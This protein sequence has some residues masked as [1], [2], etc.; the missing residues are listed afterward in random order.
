MPARQRGASHAN[1]SGGSAGAVRLKG[2]LAPMVFLA[3][4]SIYRQ[5]SEWIPV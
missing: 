5:K 4:C 2:E 1:K 3:R